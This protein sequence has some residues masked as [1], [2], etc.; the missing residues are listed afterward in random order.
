MKISLSQYEDVIS[1]DSLS[2][3][4]IRVVLALIFDHLELEIVRERTPDYTSFRL[5]P[6]NERQNS[7]RRLHLK[8]LC[9]PIKRMDR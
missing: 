8:N 7:V 5:R 2:E 6:R 4:E 9:S 3:D 1:P